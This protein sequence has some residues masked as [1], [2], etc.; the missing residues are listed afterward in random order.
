MP[1]FKIRCSL[2]IV[3][4]ACASSLFAAPDHLLFTYS[5]DPSTTLTAN[6]QSI[7][8]LEGGASRPDSGQAVV[9][10]DTRS[11]GGD[12]TKYAKK[13]VGGVETIEG[14]N[15]RYIYRA[16]LVG[17]KP[18]ET[19]YIVVGNP[20]TGFSEE[21]KVKTIPADDS[22]L[23]F[24]TGGDMGTSEDT[25][26]LLRHSATYAPSFAVIGGDIAYANGAL[27]SVG[28]WDTWLNYYTE[29]MVT[30]EGYTIPVVLAIG[31][32]EVS[33]FYNK[34]KSHAPFFFGLFAQDPDKSYFMR[35][36][37]SE[38]ALLV[39]DSGHV[40][41]HES[42][43]EWLSESLKKVQSIRH[44]AAVYHIP[45]YPTHRGFMEQYSIAGREYWASVFDEFGL[46]VAFENHDHTFKR[47]YPIKDGKV[48]ED[49]SGTL[50]LG[51]GCWGRDARD[52]DY[53][54]RWY[55]DAI[56]SIQHFWVVNVNTEQ[57]VYRAVD[58][59][60]RVFDVYPQDIA[61][62]NEAATVLASVKNLYRVPSGVVKL[63]DYQNVGAHWNGGEVTI[64]LHNTL[65]HAITIELQKKSL[66]GSITASGLPTEPIQLKPGE[67]K[68]LQVE[69]HP[70]DAAARKSKKLRVGVSVMIKI[71][72][73]QRSE[74]VE[75][76]SDFWAA[77]RR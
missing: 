61:G 3:L 48:T 12:H 67:K 8:E 2:I 60:N 17:L 55:I 31:N 41:T 4:L 33:G 51:D 16:Q 20:E 71:Q 26:R 57:M 22:P 59:E 43:V 73:P 52:I 70:K 36:F 37:G 75:L 14:L 45:L 15:D 19:Y 23:C 25:R 72:N 29:E 53:E 28:L 42:Q 46:T 9:Y 65:E 21:V 11:R 49:G 50:Y 64:D 76:R 68:T 44:K 56:G 27:K 18:D 32:H 58:M 6:W 66:R 1:F 62:A 63:S 38:F 35:Q 13:I 34:P 10:Y 54:K 40:A 77:I 74:P 47:S 24:V 30:P 7:Y 39:L 69:F 5:G